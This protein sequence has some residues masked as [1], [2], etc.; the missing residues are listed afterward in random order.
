MLLSLLGGLLLLLKHVRASTADGPMVGQ[1]PGSEKS[2]RECLAAALEG[3]AAISQDCILAVGRLPIGP[4]FEIQS[5][6]SQFGFGEAPEL[7]E[8][9]PA[10]LLGLGCREVTR[11]PAD[12]ELS[13]CIDG[14]CLQFGPKVDVCGRDRASQK[15]LPS[16]TYISRISEKDNSSPR[17]QCKINNS[18]YFTSIDSLSG[19]AQGPRTPTVELPGRWV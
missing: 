7:P 9:V 1:V 3:D 17:M 5:Q 16:P 10:L 6:A 13:V 2:S 12:A 18:S 14:R 15:P 8:G 19:A 4:D 11:D